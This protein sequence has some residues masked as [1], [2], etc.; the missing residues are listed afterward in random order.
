[1]QTVSL[2]QCLRMI[3]TI[4]SI[5]K[6]ITYA[7][8]L[9]FCCVGVA[10]VFLAKYHP[11]LL[12]DHILRYFVQR[13]PYQK[14]ELKGIGVIGDSQSD[15]YRSDDN[16]GSNYSNATFNWVEIL[17]QERGVD[18]GPWS[19]YEE[20][21]RQ[22]YEYNFAR[23]GATAQS[24]IDQN[25][26]V[27][28]ATYVKNENVNV[29][30]IF[31]GAN[32]YAPFIYDNQYDQL[33][34]EEVSPEDLFDKQNKIVA[35]IETA[36]ETVKRSGTPQIVIVTIP[37]WGNLTT[38][39]LAFPIPMHRFRVTEA[40]K[41]TNDKIM[42]M[43]TKYDGVTI[44]DIQEYYRTLR[45]SE[46]EYQVTVGGVSLDQYLPQNNPQSALL[47]DGIH[48][49]T[50]LNGLLANFILKTVNDKLTTPIPL[51]TDKEILRSAGIE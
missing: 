2:I 28:L 46:N 12:T 20:P 44:I 8:L 16:R 43:A 23:S 15:E 50:I 42:Q 13:P 36:V 7:F 32:D 31:I 35:N 47:K 22:G 5:F 9:F 49:G 40:I 33:Y 21:R 4:Q 30:I 3:R 14:I 27:S 19:Y 45:T 17:A 6:F 24:M 1:M 25:Q 38:V 29:V 51:L 39:K 34:R 18:F 37:D 41:T 11:E 10:G 26:H 48:S